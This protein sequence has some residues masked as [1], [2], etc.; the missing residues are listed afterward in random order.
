MNNNPKISIIVPVYNV[1]QY[2]RRCIDSILNQSFADFE[3]LLIDDGSKDKSGA[4]CDEYAA[5]DSRI[6]VFHKENGGVSSARNIGLENA[7]GEWLSFIDGD[8]VIT[9]GY[10]NIRENLGFSCVIETFLKIL[11]YI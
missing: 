1:E 10:F 8:D 7:R 6:R 3:L 4:I 11:F 2:L 5:K 9:E